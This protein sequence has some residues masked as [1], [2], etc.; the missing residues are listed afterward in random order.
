M[1]INQ[2]KLFGGAEILKTSAMSD[3]SENSKHIT[4][5]PKKSDK[6]KIIIATFGGDQ[7]FYKDWALIK[8]TKIANQNNW[9]PGKIE[10]KQ[11]TFI[12]NHNLIIL[13]I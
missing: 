2:N 9:S 6:N 10:I 12:T 4:V 1:I 3:D 5:S 11:K 13:F 8:I 7:K